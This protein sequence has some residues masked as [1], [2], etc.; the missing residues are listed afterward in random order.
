MS[1]ELIDKIKPKNNG[2]FPLIDACDVEMPNGKRLDKAMEA[3]IAMQLPE[4]GIARIGIM[5][6]LGELAELSVGFP[7][8]AEL[9]DLLYVCFDSGEIPTALE[10]TTNNYGGVGRLDTKANAS[11]ELMGMWIGTKWSVLKREVL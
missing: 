5:Y 3:E 6:F 4:D 10:F 2:K 9:G 8:T 1:I 7:E 11:Y